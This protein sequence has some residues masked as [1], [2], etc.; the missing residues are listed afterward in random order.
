MLRNPPSSP[1]VR[2]QGSSHGHTIA[3]AF[4]RP[5][6]E[7]LLIL[8]ALELALWW[9]QL[10]ALRVAAVAVLIIV[11]AYS[12]IRLRKTMH[13][14]TVHV[15]SVSSSLLIVTLVTLLMVGLLIL[16]GWLTGAWQGEHLIRFSSKRTV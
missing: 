11:C 5:L 14:S 7:L 9:F 12:R 16:L 15:Q 3:R 6:V 13:T 4:A 10:A 8:T 1:A 2:R